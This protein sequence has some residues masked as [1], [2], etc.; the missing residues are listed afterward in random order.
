[1][2]GLPCGQIHP[3][4][5]PSSAPPPVSSQIT[6]RSSCGLCVCVCVSVCVELWPFKA[7]SS[8][9]RFPLIS[10]FLLPTTAE[11]FNVC[12]QKEELHFTVR[13]L[14]FSSNVLSESTR[15]R[16]AD[17]PSCPFPPHIDSLLRVCV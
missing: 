6:S 5:A 10:S 4:T 7:S 17:G 11:G 2:T 15:P 16:L 13:L 12:G 8:S 14:A 1:M 3:P 9:P